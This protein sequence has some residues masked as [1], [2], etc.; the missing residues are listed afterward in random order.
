MTRDQV[1]AKAIAAGMYAK[2]CADEKYI[3]IEYGKAEN[4]NER[5]RITSDGALLIVDDGYYWQIVTTEEL[6][7]HL[8]AKA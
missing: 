2:A 7:K 1:I 5:M 4:P 6:A 3:A 8:E